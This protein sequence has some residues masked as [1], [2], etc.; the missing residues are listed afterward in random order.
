MSWCAANGGDDGVA[1]SD[2]TVIQ[3]DS[4]RSIRRLEG[5]WDIPLSLETV[6]GSSTNCRHTSNLSRPNG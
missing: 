1:L 5:V 3:L 6:R 2:G 4:D